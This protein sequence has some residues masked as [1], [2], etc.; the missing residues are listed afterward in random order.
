MPAKTTI[1]VRR[2]TAANWTSAN[3]VLAAGEHGYITSGTN[4]GM[5]KIGDGTTAWASLSLQNI[6]G[7]TGPTGPQ[8]I[9]GTKGNDGA[10]G[11]DGVTPVISVTSTISNGTPS[12]AV[13]TPSANNYRFTFTL[14]TVPVG[15]DEKYACFKSNGEVTISNSKY[16]SNSCSGTQYKILLDSSP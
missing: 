15:Y 6:V 2:D 3:P 5:F 9:Q 14:P 8:G 1:Q 4:A 7:P 16:S 13:S 12:V 11:K 10:A